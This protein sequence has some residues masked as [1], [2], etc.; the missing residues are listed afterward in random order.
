MEATENRM[1]T[2][3][4]FPLLVSMALPPMVSMLI[5]SLYNIV[6]SIFVARLSEQALAAV[7]LVFPLQN[8]S[9]AFSVG[10]G[11]GLNSCIAR[12]LGAKQQKKPRRRWT[13][14]FF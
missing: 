1:G 8:L 13:T 4:L 11:V 6:D 2:K 7:S 10:M 9:L 5:Q 14:D 12:R 3:P